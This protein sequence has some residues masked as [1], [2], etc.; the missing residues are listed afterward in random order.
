[1]QRSEEDELRARTDIDCVCPSLTVG[2]PTRTSSAAHPEIKEAGD[3]SS[4]SPTSPVAIASSRSRF[5]TGS[6]L[7]SLQLG[8]R[9]SMD[10]A[11]AYGAG[12]LEFDPPRGLIPFASCTR[13]CTSKPVALTPA[14]LVTRA[15]SAPSRNARDRLCCL[16]LCIA[17]PIVPVASSK[18]RGS[19]GC[20]FGLQTQ[21][22]LEPRTGTRTRRREGDGG[23]G[24]RGGERR[25]RGERER[26]ERGTGDKET[27]PGHEGRGDSGWDDARDEGG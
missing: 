1:M 12:G 23:G 11:P 6:M 16:T 15:H 5:I 13:N 2:S 24:E 8:L 22:E 20:C 4:G 3:V 17:R 10:R 27:K 14:P 18:Q 9:S 26:E 25:T 7:V 19:F 21:G